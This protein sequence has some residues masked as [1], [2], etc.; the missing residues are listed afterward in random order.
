MSNISKIKLSGTSEVFDIVDNV[1]TYTAF[2]VHP[3]ET[4]IAAGSLDDVTG[5]SYRTEVPEQLTHRTLLR[6]AQT[7]DESDVVVD[8][9][10]GT[11]TKVSE[12]TDEFVKKIAENEYVYRLEHTYSNE[13]RYIVKIFG[14]NYFGF[15]TAW[16]TSNDNLTYNLMSRCLEKDLPVAPHLTNLS[17]FAACTL[18]LLKVAAAEYSLTNV[19]NFSSLFLYDAN[20]VEATGLKNIPNACRNAAAVF[21]G[22]ASLTS[23]DFVIPGAAKD[24]SLYCLFNGCRNLVADIGKLI[25]SLGLFGKTI[26]MDRAFTACANLTGTVPADKLWN[27]H[28]IEWTNTSSCFSKC[29]DDIRAQV[30]ESWGGTNKDLDRQLKLDKMVSTGL[31]DPNDYTAFEVQPT[32]TVIPAGTVDDITGFTYTYEVPAQMT[33]KFNVRTTA[34]L[35]DMDVI[36]DWG[37]GSKQILKDGEYAEVSSSGYTYTMAHTY[38]TPG[39]YIVKIYGKQYF[40]LSTSPFTDNSLVSR[41]LDSD[42]PVASHLTNL[43]SLCTNSKRLLKVDVPFSKI[44]FRIINTSS[45]FARCYNLVQATGFGGYVSPAMFSCSWMFHECWSMSECDFI[46]P[47]YFTDSSCIKAVFKDCKSLAVDINSLLPSQ[48]FNVK[49][50]QK[51]QIFMNTPVTGTV[52]ADILFNDLDLN[53]VGESNAFYGCSAEIRSQVP[54]SWGGTASDDIIEKSPEDKIHELSDTIAQ[55]T[56]RLEALENA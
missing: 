23:T 18:R 28:R 27:D 12:L 17:S 25:P 5:Y 29:S 53:W 54:K 34:S 10:D 45:M 16:E 41:C 40:A 20:L 33:A 8:W 55:L 11:A 7:R 4:T 19:F 36:V 14:K 39:K 30:P 56:T 51:T 24:G 9:G 48:G 26:N 1:S 35:E 3:T 2:E 52:P 22:C 50:P 42:L 31:I 43:S 21:S 32:D 44:M 47:S 37:D 15:T 13:G 46:L 38:T 6:S 49:Q